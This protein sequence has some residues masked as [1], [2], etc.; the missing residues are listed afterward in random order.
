MSKSNEPRCPACD[1]FMYL[2]T[3]NKTLSGDWVAQ[4][5]CDH[6]DCGLWECK[7]AHGQTREEAVAAA[8]ANALRRPAGQER[9]ESHEGCND[10]PKCCG[11]GHQG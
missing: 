4:F 3:S 7:A 5:Y 1:R 9:S 6:K 2:F 8:R 10:Q 11:L